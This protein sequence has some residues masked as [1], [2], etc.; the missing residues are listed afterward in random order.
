MDPTDAFFAMLM[1]NP[2]IIFSS[3][4][5][6]LATYGGFSVSLSWVWIGFLIILSRLPNDGINSTVNFN[7]FRSFSFGRCG[8]A[9]IDTFLIISQSIYIDY[10]EPS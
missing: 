7:P 8:Y 1:L 10:M 9:G 6:G 5:H 2:L 4:V 3:L